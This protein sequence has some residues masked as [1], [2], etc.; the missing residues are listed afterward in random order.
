MSGTISDPS[1]RLRGFIRG[2]RREFASAGLR[3]YSGE[4]GNED[5]YME[6]RQPWY[7]VLNRRGA[8]KC[9]TFVDHAGKTVRKQ[10]QLEFDAE[11]LFQRYEN[12]DI[13]SNIIIEK[14]S[15]CKEGRIRTFGGDKKEF[16]ADEYY[17][18]IGSIPLPQ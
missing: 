15:L 3:F 16:V 18:E 2:V 4:S 17:K 6:W 10:M 7:D 8:Q 14:L 13:A 5:E 11:A 12:F 1:G 9:E